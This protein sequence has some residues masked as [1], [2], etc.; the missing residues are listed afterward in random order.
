[1]QAA[2]FETLQHRG[3][4]YDKDSFKRVVALA[5]DEDIQ[6]RWKNFLKTI[7]NDTLAFSAVIQVI[8]TFLEPVF[9]TEV[10]ILKSI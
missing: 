2:I 10:N 1:M 7:K 9:D 3:T 8:Q 4:P 6:K 5:E